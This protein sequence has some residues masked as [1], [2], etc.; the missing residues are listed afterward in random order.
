M[1]KTKRACLMLVKSKTN[2][3]AAVLAGL[4]ALQLAMPSLVKSMTPEMF[5]AV[6][7]CI[8]V[9]IAFFRSLTKDSLGDKVDKPTEKTDE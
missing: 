9:A 1:K 2:I 5:A 8:A 4:S 3:F 7:V 6:G